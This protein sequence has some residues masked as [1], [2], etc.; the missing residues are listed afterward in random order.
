MR[1]HLLTGFALFLAVAACKRSALESRGYSRPPSSQP[2]TPSTSASPT[3]AA[4][5]SGNPGAAAVQTSS[6]IAQA[7]AGNPSDSDVVHCKARGKRHSL[8]IGT[9][10]EPV[11]SLVPERDNVFAFTYQHELAR[12]SLWRFR[13]D[14]SSSEVIGRH[15]ALGEPKSPLLTADAAYF[16]RNKDTGIR[17]VAIDDEC[18]Y[19]ARQLKSGRVLYAKSRD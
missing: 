1:T 18:F 4:L 9:L 3:P 2:T 11:V 12:V 14:G 15:T 19:T 8:S 10:R 16:L 13:R 17:A 5:P 7:G 6:A